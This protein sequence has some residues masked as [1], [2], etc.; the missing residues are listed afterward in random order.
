LQQY[1]QHAIAVSS[2]CLSVSVKLSCIGLLITVAPDCGSDVFFSKLMIYPVHH[3]T[4]K[5][6]DC[7][8]GTLVIRLS[9]TVSNPTRNL[10]TSRPFIRCLRNTSAA[11]PRVGTAHSGLLR[12]PRTVMVKCCKQLGLSVSSTC[13]GRIGMGRKSRK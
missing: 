13:D 1:I 12:A 6:Q 8:D 2:V 11:G 7:E 4:E 3:T 5:C 9:V 10:R